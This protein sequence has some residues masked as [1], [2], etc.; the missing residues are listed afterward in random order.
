MRT[1]EIADVV[2]SKEGGVNSVKAHGI[3]FYNPKVI[4]LTNILRVFSE[5]EHDSLIDIYDILLEVYDEGK[6][7][8][9]VR[10][11]RTKYGKKETRDFY[12]FGKTFYTNMFDAAMEFTPLKFDKP[13]NLDHFL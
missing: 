10:E 9:P 7:Y 5:K 8:V 2:M 3:T 11:C 13:F 4:S 12:T 6:L 1:V